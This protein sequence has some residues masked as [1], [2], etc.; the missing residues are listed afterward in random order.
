MFHDVGMRERLTQ[1]RLAREDGLVPYE[2]D[3][4][5]LPH[6]YVVNDL[7]VEL[8][9]DQKQ[10]YL[11]LLRIMWL[12]RHF[13]STAR[14]R[15]VEGNLSGATHFSEGE[16]AVP[17]GVCAVLGHDDDI[18]STHR[19]HGH[20]LARSLWEADGADQM[21]E[22]CNKTVA[23]LLGKETGYCCGRGGSMHIADV[24]S[25]NL[26]ATGIVAGNLP[27]A[28]GAGLAHKYRDERNVVACF[29]GDGATNN[30]AWHESLNAAAALLDGLPVVFVCINNGF[31]MSVPFNRASV[32]EAPRAANVSDVITR[33]LG[34]GMAGILVD[35]MDPLAVEH[36]ARIASETAREMG[37]PVLIE[38]QATRLHGHTMS[39]QQTYRTKDEK[40]KWGEVDPLVSFPRRLV[41][42]GT[43]TQHEVDAIRDE[44]LEMITKAFEFA[45]E[46]R[47]PEF[48]GY[49][50]SVYV[51][52]NAEVLEKGR[53]DDDRLRPRM[54]EIENAIRAELREGLDLST[55]EGQVRAA[56]VTTGAGKSKTYSDKHRVPVLSYAQAIAQAT[57]EEMERD[58]SVYL[59]GEDVGMYGGAYA[60]SRGL[61]AQ[62]G[63]K[64][65]IDSPISESMI[66][67]AAVGAALKGLRPIH[68]FQ[69]GDFM[70]QA[71]DQIIHNAA[72]TVSMFARKTGV[73]LVYRSQGGLG[74]CLGQH[75][76]ESLEYMFINIPGVYVVMPATPYDAKGLLK[77]SIR[78]D[79]PIIFL[80]HKLLYS[81][82]WGPVPEEDYLIPIGVADVK[83][84][85]TDVTIVTYSRMVNFAMEAAIQ[86]AE[87]GIEAEVI[88]VRSL[89]PLD[90]L[91]CVKSLRK[92]G[93]LLTLTEGY[94]PCGVAEYLESEIVHYRLD[95]GT[96]GFD[97]LDAEPVQLSCRPA[98]VGRAESLEAGM[99]PLPS[100]IV[101]TCE[102][103]AG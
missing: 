63:S 16:E 4:H 50:K 78:D 101:A 88:D 90:T 40:T 1:P 70:T 10:H 20:C 37:I 75:H 56:M 25:G 5:A 18:T 66:A 65:V 46:S 87:R 86:L 91:T 15:N 84:E 57:Q 44:A 38:A 103:L 54:H 41:D 7:A 52:L 100:D 29:H 68:E 30:G 36:A 17:A 53:S 89:K 19:G 22:V 92:T 60:A 9:D 11:D 33:A 72:Y 2:L 21:Q 94:G 81:G 77:A 98:P 14:Q 83:R 74:R 82:T 32:P 49:E 62:F 64:R 45:D 58:G 35:G 13:E 27:V 8:H 42:C 43:V 71:S 59:L 73:P 23:E 67:G 39:D 85:G 97:Y 80:E 6:I 96:S 47:F 55:P 31:G 76:S 95:D 93:R 28:V 51:P 12:I 24:E 69:Y 26:G 102:K 79:N 99:I 3:G 48:E 34:Y 61:Y